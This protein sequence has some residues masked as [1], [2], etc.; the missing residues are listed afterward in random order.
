[1]FVDEALGRRLETVE[2]HFAARIAEAFAAD[3]PAGG[4]GFLAVG[5]AVAAW[6]APHSVLS[7]VYA[8]GLD[9]P[10][11]DSEL[12]A[13]EAF[14]RERG[15]RKV[16]VELS[17]FAG[18]ELAARLED[19][20]FRL[21][22]HEQVQVRPLTAADRDLDVPRARGVTV[23]AVDPA[24]RATRATWARVSSDGFFAPQP[25][26]PD[27]ARYS[28]LC[29]DVPGTVAWLARVDGEPAGGGAFAVH[30]G[31][32]PFFAG[33]TLPAFRRRGSHHALIAARLRAAAR[34]GAAVATVG[35]RA[36]GDSHK[37]L[38]AA[39]FTVAYT[40][41]LFVRAWE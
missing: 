5:P 38:D 34:A 10:V 41:W 19:R 30:D 3:D 33:S 22:G 37:H 13:I 39:G 11:A 25:S 2:A 28:A 14:Y 27:I 15:D 23:E 31:I 24:D 21:A 17:P 4:A 16:Q 9:G 36:G 29:F 18:A 6:V 35:A 26:P 12:D 40:R 7:K 1:M 20:G 32:A 8:L